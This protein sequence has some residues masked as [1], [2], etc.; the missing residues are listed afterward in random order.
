LTCT[1]AQQHHQTLLIFHQGHPRSKFLCIFR[2][3][4]LCSTSI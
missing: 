2:T 4:S 1:S 3:I